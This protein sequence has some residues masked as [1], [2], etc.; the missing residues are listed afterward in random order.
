MSRTE[1]RDGGRSRAVEIAPLGNGRYRV[2]VDGA[3]IEVGAARLP[4]GRLSLETPQ[5]R[6]I[7]EV[8]TSGKRRFVRLGGLD[9][10]LD[11][12]PGGRTRARGAATDGGLESPM[13][14]LVTR[15]MVSAGDAVEP[16]QP[17]VAIEAMKMEHL[18][19]A[20]RRGVVRAVRARA[21]EMVAGG[22]A[23]IEL[24][25]DEPPAA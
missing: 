12:E 2:T 17:L 5:G 24:V 16:G 19:R 4:D 22:T 3:P 15:V 14:G 8:T 6:F 1:W 18:I 21:G 7:A 11:L 10:V 9:F 13:P 20:P 25:P 23:L